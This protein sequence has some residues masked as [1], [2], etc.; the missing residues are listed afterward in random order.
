[1]PL[2]LLRYLGADGPVASVA[3][4]TGRWRAPTALTNIARAP[5][6]A[7]PRLPFPKY[8]VIWET[9]GGMSGVRERARRT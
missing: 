7:R 2:F 3:V 8:M 4:I 1:M 5:V 6:D 9:E